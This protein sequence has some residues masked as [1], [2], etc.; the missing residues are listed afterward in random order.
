M[1]KKKE[2]LEFNASDGQSVTA[3]PHIGGSAARGADKGGGESSYSFSTKSEVLSAIMSQIAGLDKE[4]LAD[5]FKGLQ[6]ASG[7]AARAADKHGGEGAALRLSPSEV[8]LK[9]GTTYAHPT[10]S[11]KT[12]KGEQPLRISPTDA[13]SYKEDVEEI[14]AGD[15][16]SEEIRDKAVI[17][18]EAAINARLVSEV[19]RLE[20]AFEEKLDEAIEEVRTE[21]TENIDK[22]LSYAVKEWVEENTLAIDSGLK[23]EMADE[24]ILGLKSLFESN[25]IAIPEDK[26][27]VVAEMSEEV[28]YLKK[29]L[30]EKTTKIVKLK[31]EK[32]VL[33]AEKIFT[34]MTEGLTKT[35][36]EKLRTLSEGLSFDNAEDYKKKFGLVKETY[37]PTKKTSAAVSTLTEEVDLDDSDETPASGPM[38]A[39][40][41]AASRLSKTNI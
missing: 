14:F 41:N 17:V 35:N 37:F 25:Y 33:K 21:I 10:M 11:S 18:F 27:D 1:S 12:G 28:E 22:Y 15:E 2:L 36:V 29:K 7:S 13:H 24:F 23:V 16:L 20:E 39:Y 3:E 32:Q 34:K 19:A 6:H 4:N 40:I 26:I 9:I 30:N 5:V 8:N 38:A 31:E